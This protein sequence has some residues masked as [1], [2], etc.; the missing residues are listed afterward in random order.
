MGPG[1]LG[2]R[3]TQRQ[4]HGHPRPKTE[5]SQRVIDLA[6]EAVDALRGFK[7]GCD[8][9]FVLEGAEPATT[10]DYYRCDGLSENLNEWLRSKGVHNEGDPFF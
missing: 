6:P 8:S 3:T 4:A 9:E 1:R 5:E 2:A 7:E 10:Y